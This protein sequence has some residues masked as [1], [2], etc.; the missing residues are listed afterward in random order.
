MDTLR[1]TA[2]EARAVVVVVVVVVVIVVFGGMSDDAD[3][4]QALLARA[5]RLAGR[6]VDD[7]DAVHGGMP[8]AHK[9]GVGQRI[10]RALGLRPV[11]DD[12][13]DPDSGVEVKTLPVKIGRNGP[14]VQEVTWV[15]SATVERLIDETWA[16]S[17]VKKK[18]QHVLFVPIV[19]EGTAS[20]RIGAAFLWQPDLHEEALLRADWEDLSDLVARGL[21]FAVT[22]KRGQALHLRPKARDAQQVRHARAVDDD[23]VARPQGFYLRR[24]FTQALLVRHLTW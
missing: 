7:V 17:R 13:D 8:G 14:S 12:V 20:A 2:R 21:G 4:A 5:R 15:T 10:E 22:S 24:A 11:F 6:V 16:T 23:I 1:V 18:L 9:G 3:L 19:V